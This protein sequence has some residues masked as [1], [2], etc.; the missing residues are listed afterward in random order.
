ME[1]E[2]KKDKPTEKTGKSQMSILPYEPRMKVRDPSKLNMKRTVFL[3]FAFMIVL[4]AWSFFN[5]QVPLSI[6]LVL[7]GNPFLDIIKGT[8]MAMDNIIAVLLQPY[9]GDLSDRTKSRFGRRMPF[10]IMGTLSAVLFFIMIPF[11]AWLRVLLGL[12]LIILL[13]D[14]AM[15]VFRSASVAILPDYTS[16]K[17]YSKAS[18]L[19]Q[20][21]ANIGGIFGFAI[22]I[23]VELLFKEGTFLYEISGYM[24]T[25]ALMIVLLIILTL[26]IKETPTGE[27]FL[28]IH[29]KKLEIDSS[30][31]KV[32]ISNKQSVEVK[33]RKGMQLRSYSDAARI[34]KGNKNFAFMLA[35]VFFM[36]LAFASIEPFFS[37][38]ATSYIGVTRGTAGTLFLA[39]SVP[40]VLVA[41]FV[42]LVGQS[43]KVGRKNA[44]KI[45][46]IGIIITVTIMAFLIVPNIYN[47]APISTVNT[48]LIM[49]M[50]A[51]ISIPWM[52]FIVNSFP[53]IW[54]FAPEEEIGIYTGIYYTFN[55]LA[56]ALA[57]VL[58]GGVL[59]LFT[60]LGD[61]RYI[62]MFPFILVCIIVAFLFMLK[63]K[64]GEVSDTT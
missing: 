30:T 50:L 51:L 1:E 59:S 63:V 41:Y 57:P 56:Y 43:E 18:G 33:K 53:I 31:F 37:S 15:S 40:M 17:N 6:E 7:A 14:I 4:L 22:P 5:F 12:I 49:L 46:L 8:I 3:S 23:I 52:G 61:Y 60:Y 27:S 20:L 58:F 36:Y 10:V 54:A 29:D 38:F 13:F 16:D 24:I 35:T 21:I 9:F 55:Q 32:G 64:G 19:Q 47:I 28:K 11:M 62:I 48:V 42:G 25:G 39:Y 45:F 34:I 2:G 44:V 26:T